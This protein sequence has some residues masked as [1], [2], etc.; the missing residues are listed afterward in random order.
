MQVAAAPLATWG[1][2]RRGESGGSRPPGA[3]NKAV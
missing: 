3:G 2:A 1:D